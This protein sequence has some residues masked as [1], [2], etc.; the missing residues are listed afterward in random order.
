M[1]AEFIRRLEE[2]NPR[3]TQVQERVAVV[4]MQTFLNT[5]YNAIRTMRA[6]ANLRQRYDLPP[7]FD[8]MRKEVDRLSNGALRVYQGALCVIGEHLDILQ[9][10]DG[11]NVNFRGDLQPANA[12]RGFWFYF[13]HAGLFFECVDLDA[14]LSRAYFD[15]KSDAEKRRFVARFGYTRQ[16]GEDI[17]PALLKELV[18]DT[19]RTSNFIA[20]I[21]DTGSGFKIETVV[22][23]KRISFD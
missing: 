11:E 18:K 20:F 6:L 13:E 2:R 22:G 17:H 12:V 14:G 19:S 3:S 4:T 16:T 7:D 21:S 23:L 5:H 1:A 9:E 10:H 15:G 8:E